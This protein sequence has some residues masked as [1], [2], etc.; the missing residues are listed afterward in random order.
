MSLGKT[1]NVKSR[2]GQG[3]NPP[4]KAA[5]TG[6]S[7]TSGSGTQA[8]TDAFKAKRISTARDPSSFGDAI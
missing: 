2:V 8:N 6:S 3:H 7:S 5:G 1:V 4:V